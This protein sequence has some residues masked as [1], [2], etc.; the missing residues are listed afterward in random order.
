MQSGEMAARP[1]V[2]DDPKS[3][4]CGSATAQTPVQTPDTG[5][6]NRGPAGPGGSGPPP[7]AQD[8]AAACA[9]HMQFGPE[10]MARYMY[11]Q[12][13]PMPYPAP[14]MPYVIMPWPPAWAQ[15]APPAPAQT[16]GQGLAEPT[17]PPGPSADAA[18]AH[19][20]KKCGGHD[21][22]DHAEEMPVHGPGHPKHDAWRYGQ[23]VDVV[24]GIAGGRPDVDKIMG[25]MEGYDGQFW[26]G[27][28][29]G[30]AATLL[31]TNDT[32]KS[33]LAG[34]AGSVWGFFQK[35]KTEA[36]PVTDVPLA[37][38]SKAEGNATT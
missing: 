15:A 21:H 26:K 34:A 31:L 37:G 28:L 10:Y 11:Q 32:V 12:G 38:E 5:P 35:D 20:K 13:P 16:G 36:S 1:P 17:P 30:A 4:G 27:L 2:Q 3:C 18:A 7:Q 29:V 33:A 19:G 25:L 24:N 23:W 9:A 14:S 6:G 22:A 8:A